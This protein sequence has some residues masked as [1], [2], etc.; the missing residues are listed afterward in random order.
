MS[1][2]KI[3]GLAA[4]IAVATVCPA[5]VGHAATV[6]ISTDEGVLHVSENGIRQRTSRDGVTSYYTS[7]SG[8]ALEGMRVMAHYANGSSEAL[9]WARMGDASEE[10]GGVTGAGVSLSY[11]VRDFWLTATSRLLS[12]EIDAASGNALFDIL[13]DPEDGTGGDT[14]GTSYGFAYNTRDPDDLEG[15]IN[16]QY[17]NAVQVRGYERGTDAFTKMIVD[18]SKLSDGG[19]LGST[20]F[21]SDLDS[22]AVAGDLNPVPLPAGLPLLVL[23]LGAIALQGRRKGA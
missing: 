17:R 13:R 11:R 3:M 2:I 21:Q 22:I 4:I 5:S 6:K 23:G 16:V 9:T 18:Y 10:W 1:M 15:I 12:L 14:M 7:V 19:L 8:W 20:T